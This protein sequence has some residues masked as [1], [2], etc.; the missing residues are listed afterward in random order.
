MRNELEKLLNQYGM[1][2]LLTELICIMDDRN[3]EHKEQY[4]TQLVEDL[5]NT[6]INYTNRYN[7]ESEDI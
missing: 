4:L 6:Y 2:K 1:K 7:D 3:Q 5:Q